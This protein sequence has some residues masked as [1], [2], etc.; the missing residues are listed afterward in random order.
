MNSRPLN[1]IIEARGIDTTI[2]ANALV[3]Y[4]YKSKIRKIRSWSIIWLTWK[5][6]PLVL[7]VQPSLI[8]SELKCLGKRA[9]C[10]AAYLPPQR[11][12]GHFPLWPSP[13]TTPLLQTQKCVFWLVSQKFHL[14]IYEYDIGKCSNS[15]NWIMPLKYQLKEHT[16]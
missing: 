9:V 8:I 11:C 12:W 14:G 1:S 3:N 7:K 6:M 4:N 10:L 16:S 2:S 15:L 13:N 5:R